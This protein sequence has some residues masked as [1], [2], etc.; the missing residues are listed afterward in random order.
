MQYITNS[1]GDTKADRKKTFTV[2]N[3]GTNIDSNNEQYFLIMAYGF[4]ILTINPDLLT[5]WLYSILLP[6]VAK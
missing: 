2:K 4:L 6:P 5:F 3:F 1:L